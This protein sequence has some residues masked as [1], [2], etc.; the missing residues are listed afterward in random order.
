[1]TGVRL[2]T[3]VNTHYTEWFRDALRILVIGAG[4]IGMPI[5]HY[6][7][8]KG[9]ILTVIESDEEK[10][11]HIA[12]H[13]DAAIFKGSGADMK[14]WRTAKADEMDILLALTNDDEVNMSATWIAKEQYGVPFVIARAR[15]PEN[16]HKMKELG[17]EIIISPSLETRRLFL[18][19][20]EGLA[21]ETLCEYNLADFKSIRV[22]I[23]VDGSAI[24]KTLGQLEIGKSC[25]AGAVIRNNSYFF[26]DE[27]FVFLGGDRVILLGDSKCVG[28]TVEKMKD[29]QLP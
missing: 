28:K 6:L 27:S 14:M 15:Q 4:D 8:E 22:T 25:K 3:Q 5:I 18:N 24:G 20:I 17:A 13:A 1:M 26:P 29:V 19:A 12:E 16:I 21:A 11:R 9:H 7:S 2:F 23:P 10:C